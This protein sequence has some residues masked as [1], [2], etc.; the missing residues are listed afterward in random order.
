[1]RGYTY[2]RTSLLIACA[3]TIGF[4]YLQHSNLQD[5][6]N[7]F[8]DLAKELL[9]LEK[10]ITFTQKHGQQKIK[11]EN[12]LTIAHKIR[13]CASSLHTLRFR[14]EPEMTPS[15]ENFH[16]FKAT[17]IMIEAHTILDTDVFDFISTI[18]QKFPETFIL[19]KVFIQRNGQ[20]MVSKIYYAWFYVE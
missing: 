3:L 20:I 5:R 7:E 17:N 12:R 8:H 18:A 4:S 1:M 9:R 13:Q 15:I 6:T 14:F 11:P 16:Y 10:D 2:F 19:R